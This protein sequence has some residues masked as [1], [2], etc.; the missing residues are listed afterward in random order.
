MAKPKKKQRRD[1]PLISKANLNIKKRREDLDMS[2]MELDVKTGLK[3]YKYESGKKEMNLT[4]I[5]IFA[6][7]LKTEAYKLLM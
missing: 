2:Q 3:S 6:K 5:G 7:A 1:T 4:T